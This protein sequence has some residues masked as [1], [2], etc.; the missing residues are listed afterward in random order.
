MNA[1]IK[2]APL[3]VCAIIDGYIIILYTNIQGV[4]ET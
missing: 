3:N 1:K 2:N 4:P